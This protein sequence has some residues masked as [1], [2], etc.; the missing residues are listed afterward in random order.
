MF[1]SLI[2]RSISMFS[3]FFVDKICQRQL[4]WH[5]YDKGIK[6]NLVK[7]K[8]N[9]VRSGLWINP[10]TRA[11]MPLHN[12]YYT[13]KPQ[14]ELISDNSGQSCMSFYNLWGHSLQAE[15]IPSWVFLCYLDYF[16]LYISQMTCIYLENFLHFSQKQLPE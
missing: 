3:R 15:R 4:R 1:D 9:C 14:F 16:K 12:V 5:R 2:K 8:I 7:K 10:V 6:L 11:V 13:Y